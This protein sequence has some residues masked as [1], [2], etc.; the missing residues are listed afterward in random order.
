MNSYNALQWGRNVHTGSY[1]LFLVQWNVKLCENFPHHYNL[2][3]SASFV[4]QFRF[5]VG[6]EY[7]IFWILSFMN[8]IVPVSGSGKWW[9]TLIEAAI[10]T[11]PIIKKPLLKSVELC[12]AIIS[13]HGLSMKY[14]LFCIWC[15]FGY[16]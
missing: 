4:L 13:F 2:M 1:I 5:K 9:Y 12:I 15:S 11:V 8:S 3:A 16:V 10:E 14:F 7:G 6:Y